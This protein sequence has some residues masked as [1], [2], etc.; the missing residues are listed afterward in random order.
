MYQPAHYTETR[1]EVLHALLRTHPLAALI[2]TTAEGPVADH[3]PLEFDPAAGPIGTLRGHVARA[4]P[5]WQRHLGGQP[6]LAIFQG[7]AAYVSPSFYPSKQAD[8]RVVPTWNYA[9]V[10]ATGPITFTHD[11]EWLR[12]LVGRLTDWQESART[13]PWHVEDAP[14][15]FVDRMLR[16]IVGFEIR[17]ERLEGKWKMSQNQP[18]ANRAGVATGLRNTADSN[19]VAV[20]QIVETRLHESDQQHD[21]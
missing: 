1:P 17:I 3:V 10:H 14:G 2:T 13:P 20:A 4:N 8:P 5:M 9:V 7:P 19:A 18:A 6:V 21:D 11:A 12:R 15:D 16:A